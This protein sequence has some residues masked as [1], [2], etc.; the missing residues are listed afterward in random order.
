MASY[1]IFAI[2]Q[3]FLGRFY[4]E[5]SNV[6]LWFTQLISFNKLPDPIFLKPCPSSYSDPANCV[7]DIINIEIVIETGQIEI[8]DNFTTN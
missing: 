2:P 5:K 1:S 6:G 8:L 3:Q 7:A 4:G